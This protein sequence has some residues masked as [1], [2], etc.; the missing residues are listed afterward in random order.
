MRTALLQQQQR[1][2]APVTPPPLPADPWRYWSA[3]T[4][5]KIL[6]SPVENVETCW[7]LIY[8]ELADLGM[9]DRPVAI[10]ALSTVGVESGTFLPVQESWWLPEGARRAYLER[11]YGYQTD[12]GR[13]L[14]NILPG[15][16]WRYGGAGWIQLSGRSNYRTYGSLIGVDLEG[17][18]ELALVPAYAAK[19][20][21]VYFRD[22]RSL[23][24]YNMADAA[25][26]GL[27]RLSR[28]LV[29]GGTNG[30]PEYI[31]YVRR[32]EAA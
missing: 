30:W 27:W 18:P 11:M 24:G 10:V 5:S 1:P 8:A 26:A 2:R 25:R 17:H 6:G 29:N 19:V 4:I 23:D 9:G 21:A 28:I 12:I 13:Q 7:P 22:H 32:L 14:G 16:G 15:D 3:E 20:F 31:S